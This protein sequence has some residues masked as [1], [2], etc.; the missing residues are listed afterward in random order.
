MAR[1]LP[2]NS[3]AIARY[4]GLI[5]SILLFLLLVIAVLTFNIY[6]SYL[7]E[8]NAAQVAATQQLRGLTQTITRDLYDLK[9]SQGE[10]IRSPHIQSTVARLSQSKENF[11][12]I[13]L[14]FKQSGEITNAEGSTFSVNALSA[15]NK[16]HLDIIDS[17]W[18]ILNGKLDQY[19]KVASNLRAP[20]LI[21]DQ[22]VDS[23]QGASIAI[24]N[25]SNAIVNA[26]DAASHKQ[27]NLIRYLQMGA[28][29]VAVVYFIVFMLYFVRRLTNADAQAK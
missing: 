29:S 20:V 8:R 23:A 11:S 5:K 18:D 2:F 6:T 9:L 22:A 19:L 21:L 25:S 26:V 13:L 15:A 12:K 24:Y 14:A 10:D 17:Q 7:I 4:S 3:A 28:I 1:R 27:A 16:A